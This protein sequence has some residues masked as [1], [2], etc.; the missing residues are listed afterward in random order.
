MTDTWFAGPQVTY[1]LCPSGVNAMLDGPLPTS[2]SATILLALVSS[3]CTFPAPAALTKTRLPSGMRRHAEGR[4]CR[5]HPG[6]YRVARDIDHDHLAVLLGRD[7]RAR[8]VREERDA[9]RSR[10]HADRVRH[11]TL[12]DV[13]DVERGAFL[14]AGVY[15]TAVRAEDRVRR[16]LAATNRYRLRDA[17]RRRSISTISALPLIAAARNLPSGLRSI[18]LGRRPSIA[19]PLSA[20]AYMS[21]S[22]SVPSS[23]LT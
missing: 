9:A 7:I 10:T 18:E 13:D 5:F 23:W 6:E 16:L 3:T 11:G 20:F 4:A 2:N 12:L 21:R 17:H 22:M 1:S 14:R 15:P 8:A 19:R